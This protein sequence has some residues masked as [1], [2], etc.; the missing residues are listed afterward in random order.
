ML[1]CV[2][3]CVSVRSSQ[4]WAGG[5]GLTFIRGAGVCISS[6]QSRPW[7]AVLHAHWPEYSVLV[8]LRPSLTRG[9]L[10]GTWLLCCHGKTAASPWMS[11]ARLLVFTFQCNRSLHVC[12][13]GR[14]GL[15]P[16]LNKILWCRRF[17]VG[18]FWVNCCG[19]VRIYCGL[20]ED[21]W[22]CTTER[23][24][25][26]LILLDV[27]PLVISVVFE[28]PS[29]FASGPFLQLWLITATLV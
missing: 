2:H 17:A 4:C 29:H 11:L 26:N 5:F 6:Y 24:L 9:V 14:S 27:F 3:A 25:W 22:H 23:D 20:N 18:L 15:F 28:C 12:V 16:F 19:G 10:F 7:G 21:N 13:T 1:V 8:R